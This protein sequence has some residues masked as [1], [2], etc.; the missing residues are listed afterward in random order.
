VVIRNFSEFLSE[1]SLTETPQYFIQLVLVLLC[2]WA[3]KGGIEVLGRWASFVFNIL[4]VIIMGIILMTLS[5]INFSNFTPILYEGFRPV[6]DGA[7]S[8][9]SFP[10]AETV[11]FLAIL[12]FLK[13]GANGYKVYNLSL[14]IGGS[15]LL[16]IV[17][18]NIGVLGYPFLATQYYP[19]YIAVSLINL[20]ELLE[21]F[22]VLISVVF[23]LCGF[24]KVSVCLFCAATGIARI[25]NIDDYRV[26]TVPV[27]LLMLNLGIFIYPN[28]QEMFEWVK[29]YKYYAIPFQVLLPLIIWISAEAKARL[30][31]SA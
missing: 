21:R 17:I 20:S 14:L 16:L 7:F 25:F 4:L 28:M 2:V 27:A 11:V 5:R 8:V 3:V 30:P 26:M 29:V 15:I 23:L 22:E 18:G 9:F 10:L 19:S 24:V 12:S 6:I 1:I 13:P 31:K